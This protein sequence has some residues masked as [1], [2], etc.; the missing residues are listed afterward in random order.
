MSTEEKTT[1]IDNLQKYGIT[2]QNKCI[3]CL[4][5]DQ[6]FIERIYDILDVNYFE[7]DSQ[8]W[9]VSQILSYFIEYKSLPTMEVFKIK[10]DTIEN[11]VQRLSVIQT[12]RLVYQYISSNDST[13]IKNEFLKFCKNQKMKQAV[14]DSV[15]LLER[16]QYDEIYEKMSNAMKAGVEKNNG[17]DYKKDIDKR[18]VNACRNTTKTGWELLDNLMDGGLAPGELGIV[19]ANAGAGKSWI[20]TACGANAI[21]N[22]KNVLHVTLELNEN[23]TGLRYDSCLTG[24]DFQNIRKN[25]NAVR[26]RIKKIPG[27][28]IIKYFPSSTVSPFDIKMHIDKLKMTGFNTDLLIIDYGDILRSQSSVKNSNSYTEAGNIYSEIRSIAGELNIPVWTASQANRCSINDDII[29]ADSISDSYRKVMIGD[30]VFSLSRK[31]EDKVCNTG[32]I[33]VI[34]NRFGSDGITYPVKMNAS[35]GKLD[36]IDFHSSEGVQLLKC[37]EDSSVM[38][39]NAIKTRLSAIQKENSNGKI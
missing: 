14:I 16:G 3:S 1:I 34:K 7:S 38:F 15:E 20:L 25:V 11:N 26:E 21:K 23:Y 13:F 33:H 37:M 12:L 24:I 2:F 29:E 6:T 22:G 8:K 35:C 36:I 27:K 30:F 39:K 28:L 32:R 17:H 18:M 10:T 19:I 4:L 9:I 31:A 5:S